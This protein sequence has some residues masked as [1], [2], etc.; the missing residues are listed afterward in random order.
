MRMNQRVPPQVGVF[1][2]D[3]PDMCQSEQAKDRT[4]GDI[5]FLGIVSRY[6]L[7]SAAVRASGSA[8]LSFLTWFQIGRSS[9]AKGLDYL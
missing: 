4:G 1:R 6:V 7:Q 5:G 2:E 9:R 8:S 3:T